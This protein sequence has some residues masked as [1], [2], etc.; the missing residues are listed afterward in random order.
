MTSSSPATVLL[1]ACCAPCSAAVVERLLQE[2][3]RPLVYFSNA[4]I[5]PYT[6]YAH[7]LSELG[8][9]LQAQGVPLVVAPYAHSAWLQAVAGLEACPE[10]GARCE[11]CF[12]FRLHE[13]ARAAAERGIPLLATS[14][15]ASRWKD[16]AQ[17]NAAGE[18]AVAQTRGVAFWG[19]NW[20]KGG[21]QERRGELIRQWGFYNQRWCGCEF[22]EIR[23]KR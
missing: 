9:F 22:S 3:H 1:H 16:V 5:H 10:R 23:E 19:R 2:G 14:L 7:R 12:R 6:E 21:L 15:A 17:V 11:A 8:R 13:A 18:W 20:R 4:N